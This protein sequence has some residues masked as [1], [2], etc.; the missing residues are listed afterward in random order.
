[1]KLQDLGL[2]LGSGLGLTKAMVI[3]SERTEFSQTNELGQIFPWQSDCKKDSA[4][5]NCPPL[6]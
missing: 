2:G 3:K 1:M 4:F 5:K 6:I